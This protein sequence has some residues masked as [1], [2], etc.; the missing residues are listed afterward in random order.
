[1]KI[2][3]KIKHYLFHCPTFWHPSKWIECVECGAKMICYWNG[4][5]CSCGIIDLCNR[6]YKRHH[7]EHDK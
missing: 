7:E 5:D 2:P 4:Y 3:K 1:M 6:C